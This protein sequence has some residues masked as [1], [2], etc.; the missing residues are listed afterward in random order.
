[1]TTFSGLVTQVRQQLMGY[2]RDQQA[3][4]ELA[5]GMT[6]TDTTFT[7][8][9]D[10][11]TSISRGLVEVDDE[12]ILVKSFDRTSGQVS[13][14]GGLNGRGAEGTTPAAHSFQALVTSG[15][16]FPR[17]R[18]MEAI[19][20]TIRTLS[21]GLV[22]FGETD[23]VNLSV[24]YE[25]G[26]PADATDVWSVSDQ[27]V[28]PSQVW[29]QGRTWKFITKAPTSAFPTGK[30]VQ[31]LD[32]VT[33]GRTMHVVYTKD[34]QP[35]VNAADDWLTVTGLPERAA[36]LAVWG[37]CA[38][39]LPAYEAARLQQSSIEATERAPLVPVRSAASA[40]QYYQ[41]MFDKRLAEERARMFED[42]PQTQYFAGS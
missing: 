41:L 26:M 20:A 3:V 33:P 25:Y 8:S 5:V 22:A 27:T 1:M 24:V 18:V 16:T 10:T 28:G 17:V 32:A 7:V 34:P 31:L 14:F 23:I 36:D 6:D 11:V 4:A 30:S 38:R 21:P 37:A 19:N 29:E 12:L 2:A 13:V 42:V 35:L 9:Q 15:V 40:A 39:L